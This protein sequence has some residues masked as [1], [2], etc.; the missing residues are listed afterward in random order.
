MSMQ[1]AANLLQQY[2]K[3]SPYKR[4]VIDSKADQSNKKFG[5]WSYANTYDALYEKYSRNKNFDINMWHDA[6][7]LGEQDQYL[8]FL[9]Q[10]KDNTLSKQFYDPQY[11]DYEAMMMEMYLPFADNTKLEKYTQDVYDPAS[12]KWVTEDLGEMTQRQYYEYLL[13]NTRIAQEQQ[14]TKDL[15]QWRKDQLGW[16]GQF[17]HDALATL[18]E[19]GEG[20]LSALAGIIDFAAAVGTG[21][22][23]PYAMNGFEGNYLDAF[24][25]YFG[26]NGLTVAEKRT[27]RA[28]LDEYERTHTHFRDIDG[29]MTGVGQ[30]VAGIANSIG[31][32]VPAIVA[33]VATGGAALVGTTTFYASIF[34]NNMYENATDINRVGS[35]SWVKI[36]NAFFKTAA[37]AVIEWG[38]G[39]ILGGTIQNK[40][41]GIG[42][43]N[44]NQGFI[45][46]FSKTSGLKYL[47]KSAGQEGLEEFLQ[48]F[49]TDCIDQFYSLWLEGYGKT[50]VTFQTL[51]DSF[52]VGA[53]SSIFMSGGQVALSA[54]RSTATNAKAKRLDAKDGGNRYNTE[55]GIGPGDLVIETKDGP[56]KVTGFNRL[57]YSAILSDFQKAVDELKR[58]KINSEKNIGLAQEVYGAVSAISQFYS[59]FDAERIKNC[60]LLLDRVVKAEKFRENNERAASILTEK[61]IKKATQ[62]EV[63]EAAQTFAAFTEATFRSMVGDVALRHAEKLRA[64]TEKVE[65]K[66]TKEGGVTTVVGAVDTDGIQYK[67]DPQIRDAEEYLGK[68]GM[69]VL[70]ELRKG[71]EW[72]IMT[73][74]HIACETGDMHEFLFVSEAWLKNYSASDIYKYLEQTR[75]LETLASDKMLAPMVK[76]LIAFDKEFTGQ[77]DVDAEH[78]L[79]DLLFNKSVY[80]AFLLSNAGKNMHEFKAFIFQLHEIVKDFGNRSKY[81]RQLF[82]GKQAQ[83]RINM[84]NQ[85]YEQIK[86]YLK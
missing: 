11:Y 7:K 70:D 27:V 52:C 15:E 30:Y 36:T 28:A 5:T 63:K 22:L 69:D 62:Y 82:K 12:G 45:N 40:M 14:I 76:K 4:N 57:Y 20:L 13:S 19:F 10:N 86:D 79:M 77:T 2:N 39:K 47:F 24:V 80:Q 21:G 66:L 34:S 85:I 60:E 49:S 8:A 41:I 46:G 26:E 17:G 61:T 1:A 43:R 65:E 74:G 16:W 56:Q 50:G 6:I 33:N 51:I 44:I 42:G 31:M 64:A 9:E 78:A 59:S 84:L 81:H 48:D 18:S 72:V 25:D 29:N 23:F 53:L 71:Y 83:K 37:E 3:K 68:K 58:G 73:D 55:L 75:I 35:P 32:M 38:L 54:A 67:K